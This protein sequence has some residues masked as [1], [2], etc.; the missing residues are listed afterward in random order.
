MHLSVDTLPNRLR[1]LG[2]ILEEHRMA[3]EDKGCNILL[4]GAFHFNRLEDFRGDPDASRQSC[5]FVSIRQSMT[6]MKKTPAEAAAS[7]EEIL[8][9]DAYDER[10]K[11]I[12][13]ESI[14]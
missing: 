4:V 1:D 14:L 9:I 13:R 5:E 11:K 6:S 3:I 10:N 2:K 8:G 12:N 7:N